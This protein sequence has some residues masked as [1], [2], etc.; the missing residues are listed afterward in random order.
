MVQRTRITD[1]ILFY[2]NLFL[3]NFTS[4]NEFPEILS[5]AGWRFLLHNYS[6][7]ELRALM[8]SRIHER[9]CCPSSWIRILY[10]YGCLIYSFLRPTPS[11]QRRIII[12]TLHPHLIYQLQ[13]SHKSFSL[14]RHCEPAVSNYSTMSN[15]VISRQGSLM[16]ATMS[17]K[18]VCFPIS[19]SIGGYTERD[20]I[21]ARASCGVPVPRSFVYGYSPWIGSSFGPSFRSNIPPLPSMEWNCTGATMSNKAVCFPC[22]SQG[23]SYVERDL[24]GA[25]MSCHTP[26]P[27]S[28]MYFGVHYYI[29]AYPPPAVAGG[30]LGAEMSSQAP[31]PNSSMYVGVQPIKRWA[32]RAGKWTWEVANIEVSRVLISCEKNKWWRC[33]QRWNFKRKKGAVLVKRF[34]G[35]GLCKSLWKIIIC[36]VLWVLLIKCNNFRS[37]S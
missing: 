26:L 12:T 10:I 25:E 19:R 20:L 18:A 34:T 4:S 24:L 28:S 5:V 8:I 7:A 22:T 9:Y 13:S 17:N 27:N 2:V 14:K 21:G 15:S 36:G 37:K 31:R 32:S 6:F 11:K 16:G 35:A 1:L 23:S 33:I 30:L 29:N 3:R